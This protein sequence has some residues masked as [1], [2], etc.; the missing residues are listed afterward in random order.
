MFFIKSTK[1]YVSGSVGRL[2]EDVREMSGRF[3]KRELPES[4]CS[5]TYS[6]CVVLSGLMLLFLIFC[7][8]RGETTGI[9][10][11]SVLFLTCVIMAITMY[12]Y[13]A[14]N[15]INAALS[16]E[17]NKKEKIETVDIEEM[18]RHYEQRKE[19]KAK[20]EQRRKRRS[21]SENDLRNI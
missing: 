10:L 3:G 20:Q 2:S 5:K 21:V 17:E 11:F 1:K 9:V 12:L 13:N 4:N 6:N 14:K 19:N 7:I 18:K 15:N 16:G 8:V